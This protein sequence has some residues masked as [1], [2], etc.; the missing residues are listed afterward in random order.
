M[1]FI[2]YSLLLVLVSCQSEMLTSGEIAKRCQEHHDPE[3]DWYNKKFDLVLE[4]KSVF[5]DNNTEIIELSIDNRTNSFEYN[6]LCRGVHLE[7]GPDT[8]IARNDSS[9]CDD[10][11]WTYNFYPYIWGMASKF[12]DPGVKVK[13][14]FEEDVVNEV[15][16]YVIHIDYEKEN[17]DF[18]INR[19]SYY[20]EGFRFVKNDGSGGEVVY[21]EGSKNV[22]GILMPVKRTWYDLD[23]KLLGT[24]VL[25]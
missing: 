12:F 18:Y 11:R 9:I 10:Y 21:N 3:G 7:Y 15:P 20:L 17:Y 6:N 25:K 23:M 8:C 4:S 24:D 2:G 19:D 13:E 1:K 5:S 14:A 22:N 16:V